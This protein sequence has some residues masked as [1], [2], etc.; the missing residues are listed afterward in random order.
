MNPHE[1]FSHDAHKYLHF[2]LL[3]EFKAMHLITNRAETQNQEI[4]SHH[5]QLSHTQME[6]TFFKAQKHF[7]IALVAIP[8]LPTTLLC[9]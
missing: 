6:C 5:I 1:C 4:T 9:A 2:H 3:D 7:R 8:K